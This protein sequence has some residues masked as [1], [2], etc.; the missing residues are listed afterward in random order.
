MKRPLTY[1][2]SLAS[3][4]VL[5]A[6]ASTASSAMPVSGSLPDGIGPKIEK[7]WWV[8]PGW[9]WRGPGWGWRGPGWGWRGPG[10]GWGRGWCY[11]HPYAC[12]RWW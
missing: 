9:G 10:W 3:G 1:A 4:A 5:L 2:L 12:R 6:M 11:W 7:A 8:G